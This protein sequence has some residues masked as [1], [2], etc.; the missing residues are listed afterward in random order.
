MREDGETYTRV[1]PDNRGSNTVWLKG[2]ED[3]EGKTITQRCTRTV[4][5]HPDGFEPTG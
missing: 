5:S 2:A 4:H 3:L 1:G